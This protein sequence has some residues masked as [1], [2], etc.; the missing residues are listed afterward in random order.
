MRRFVTFLA[1]AIL[2]VAAYAKAPNLT[3]EKLFDGRYNK[4]AGVSSTVYKNNGK[5]YR[6]L[7]VE[8]NAKVL[9]SIADALKTDAPRATHYSDHQEKDGQYT[10]M[11]VLNNG[12]TIFIGLQRDNNGGGFFFIQGAE[13]AFK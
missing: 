5:Y 2:S 7:T 8:N 4:T 3:V 10:S 11:K 1:I 13:S 12:E 6:G 9:K